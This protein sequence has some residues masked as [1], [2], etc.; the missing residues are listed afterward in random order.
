MTLPASYKV[1]TATVAN[2]D[3][4][5]VGIGTA[6]A[7]ASVLPGDTFEGADGRTVEITEVTDNTHLVIRAWPGASLTAGYYR[8]V[9]IDDAARLLGR[10]RAATA[11]LQ[12]PQTGAPMIFDGSATTDANPG[13]GLVRAN[14]ATT[15]TILY[16]S[17]TDALGNDISGRLATLDDSTNSVS[18][19]VLSFRP[20][21][22]ANAFLDFDVTGALTDATGYVKV[23]VTLRSGTVPADKAALAMAGVPSGE[24]GPAGTN[25]TNGTNGT[26]GL[27][28]PAGGS[29][30]QVLAKVSATDNDTAWVNQSGGG[31]GISLDDP[32]YGAVGDGVADDAG[33]LRTAYASVPNGGRIRIPAG[34]RFLL[35]SV[36][37]NGHVLTM[38][39]NKSVIFEG[40]SW[41][42]KVGGAYGAS[43]G[44]IL[45]LGSSIPDTADVF[46]W[47]GTDIVTGCGLRDFMIA[48]AP[49]A[50]STPR[51]HDAIHIDSTGASFT[52]TISGT[53]SAMAA[54]IVVP[55][56][57]LV[58]SG[59]TVG[60][61][62]SGYGT[63]TGQTGTYILDTS[64]T[65]AS[66]AMTTTANNF[67]LSGLITEHV[68]VDNMATG[69]SFRV[70]SGAGTTAGTLAYSTIR[71][72]SQMM[73]LSLEGI[74]DSVHLDDVI[75][76]QNSLSKDPSIYAWN[77]S[78]AVGF[79]AS[80]ANISGLHGQIV[81]DGG[82]GAVFLDNEHEQPAGTKNDL[83]KIVYLKGSVS[84][85][86]G[87]L[88]TG[89]SISQNSTLGKIKT[90]EIGN[91]INTKIVGTTILRANA[92]VFIDSAAQGLA[93]SI[94]SPGVLTWPDHGFDLNGTVTLSTTGALP[95]GLPAGTYY[96]KTIIDKDHVTLSATAGGAVINTSGSQSGTHTGVAPQA[97]QLTTDSSASATRHGF[98]THLTAGAIETNYITDNGTDTAEAFATELGTWTPALTPF[99]GG[100]ITA[101]ACTGSYTRRGKDIDYALSAALTSVSGT[102][103]SFSI[104]LPSSTGSPTSFVGLETTAVGTIVK[105]AQF[106]ASNS[107]NVTKYDNTTIAVN[108]AV[109]TFS[110]HYR[111]A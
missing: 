12:I 13:A 94:A 10:S 60:T 95:T 20:T 93:I 65:V 22:G 1:G 4:T 17:K 64:Q 26:D 43:L 78:G 38:A 35:N 55:G 3:T 49:G 98:N 107:I 59:V 90:V 40:D 44:S 72:Q 31:G 50:L 27:G 102:V 46:H 81:Y 63:G 57:V 82:V 21:D 18:R 29:T 52:G 6:W 89:G 34:K 5:I 48:P 97:R 84:P 28:V 96:V 106:S 41:A 105:G 56:Q 80:G 42:M 53:N 62:I 69:V 70:K 108:G 91:A 73:T 111:E 99:G 8:I 87:A 104:T 11:A 7:L 61:K 109:V 45:L 15:P 24:Q 39:D 67:F 110:G 66:E 75:L 58:G 86:I 32:T 33:A 14:D 47:C 68:F 19:A 85:V 92:N 54:G 83:G 79:V 103:L 76:G 23:P 16:I 25:G 51:G 37:A 36:D 77:T 88:I 100:T 9:A 2:G 101:G 74:G 71:R 30:G